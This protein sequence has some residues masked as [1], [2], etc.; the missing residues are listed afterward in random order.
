MK[1]VKV[2]DLATRLFH[3]LLVLLVVAAWLTIEN[4]M[5]EAHE[6]IGHSK[7]FEYG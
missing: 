5:I 4:R 2:W 6:F 3:W 1:Q 7:Q